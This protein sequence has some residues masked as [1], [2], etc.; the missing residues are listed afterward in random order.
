[1]PHATEGDLHAWLDGA[2]S[3]ID[4]EGARRLAAH[5]DRC[6]DCAARLEEERMIRGRANELLDVALPAEPSPAFAEIAGGAPSRRPRWGPERLAWAAS[7]VLALGAGWMGHALLRGT[8]DPLGTAMLAETGGSVPEADAPV[9]EVERADADASRAAARLEDAVGANEAEPRNQAPP[10]PA[11][12]QRP[13]EEQVVAGRDAQVAQQEMREVAAAPLASAA[14]FEDVPEVADARWRSSDL[15]EATAWAGRPPIVVP[16]LEIVDVG[17]A[18]AA[19]ERLVRVRQALEDG[20]VIEL[21]AR[22]GASVDDLRYAADE[23]AAGASGRSAEGV[24][25]RAAEPAPEGPPP[26]E[27]LGDRAAKAAIDAPAVLRI[28]IDGIPVI[29]TAR[30]APDSL[31]ALLSRAGPP[32]P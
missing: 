27:A 7:V 28:V 1:M 2:L 20:A 32:E 16:G 29:A 14:F 25:A 31:A 26:G 15:E 3:A 6:A 17:V 22:V 5:L 10:P 11:L 30:L 9:E 4:A 21:I 18:D 13:A 12:E 24:A 8:E 19:G 23:S